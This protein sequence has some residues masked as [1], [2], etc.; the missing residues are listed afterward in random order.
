MKAAYGGISTASVA[1]RRNRRAGRTCDWSANGDGGSVHRRVPFSTQ[2]DIVPRSSSPPTTQHASLENPSPRTCSTQRAHRTAQE[3]PGP[4]RGRGA[5]LPRRSARRRRAPRP[6]PPHRPA[7]VCVCVCVCVCARARA[8]VHTTARVR[9]CV[10]ACECVCVRAH[11]QV[12]VCARVRA[13]V[14]ACMRVSGSVCVCA[15]VCAR[16]CACVWA[17]RTSSSVLPGR[18]ASRARC[19][20]AYAP[21]A[22]ELRSTCAS[23]A[24]GRT[25][26]GIAAPSPSPSPACA[27]TVTAS[28]WV[29][30]GG[31]DRAA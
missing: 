27:L 24:L 29:G 11:V 5:A 19:E 17:C 16:V 3:R 6:E 14:C 1:Q 26:G 13:C 28:A 4:M 9:V 12:C 22:C 25:Y 20:A 2:T 31:A 7:S 8:C 18:S 15:C 10:C 21:L 23:P 30:S